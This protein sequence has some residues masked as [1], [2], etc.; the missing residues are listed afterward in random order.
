MRDEDFNRLMGSQS[1]SKHF[2]IIFLMCILMVCLLFWSIASAE[3]LPHVDEQC[4]HSFACQD[5]TIWE[6][7]Y[8]GQVIPLGDMTKEECEEVL[9]G[10]ELQTEPFSELKCRE[11]LVERQDL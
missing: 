6:L 1:N 2:A 5:D 8:Q 4:A 7:V 9:A 11:R 3:E 10:I